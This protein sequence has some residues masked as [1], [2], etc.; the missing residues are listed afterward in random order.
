MTQP[1]P[2][3]FPWQQGE[4]LAII[5]DTSS[6]KT[7]L[8]NF[9][10]QFRTYTI[11]IKTKGDPAPL[12]GREIK[13]AREFER[14]T[15][16]R[17]ILYPSFNYQWFEINRTIETIFKQGGWTLY[18]DELYRITQLRLSDQIDRLYTQ[19]RTEG[20]TTLSAM[21]RPSRIP[22]TAI[23]ETK[24]IISFV[25]EGRDIKTLAEITNPRFAATVARLDAEK[26]EFA[27]YHRPTRKIFIGRLRQPNTS[28]AHIMGS[29]AA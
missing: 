10:L 22:R 20:I 6:G 17:Y 8:A 23:A 2:L 29:L 19:G 27:W 4:H 3:P 15:E 13:T 16:K 26:F 9:L 24:H 25:L 5:G 14:G 1:Q 28:I 7:T 11:S 18:F 21:Q 12:P